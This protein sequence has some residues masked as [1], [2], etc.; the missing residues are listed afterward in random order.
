MRSREKRSF[1]A[2]AGVLAR[3]R[4]RAILPSQ[5]LLTRH[6]FSYVEVVPFST[7]ALLHV[8][9][10]EGVCCLIFFVERSSVPPPPRVVAFVFI[11][12]VCDVRSSWAPAQ[13]TT[14]FLCGINRLCQI[15]QIDFRFPRH[16]GRSLP[17]VAHLGSS[18][19]R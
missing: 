12:E 4:G 10:E 9:T 18:A 15:V 17:P 8:S 5:T 14:M 11:F 1:L 19:R 6:V 2:G 13:I 16:A 7:V 3:I